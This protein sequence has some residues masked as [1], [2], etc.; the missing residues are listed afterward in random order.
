MKEDPWLRRTGLTLKDWGFTWTVEREPDEKHFGNWVVVGFRDNLALRIIRDR[1]RVSL[2]LRPASTFTQGAIYD[3][4]GNLVSGCPYE[5]ANW[6]TWDIVCTALGIPYKPEIEPLV[7][8]HEYFER[9]NHAFAPANWHR[10][11]D[12]LAHAEAEKR[13]RFTEG[14]RVP[15]HA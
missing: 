1:D 6:Y 10:T 4:D 5:S 9:V 12:W 3:S 13:R 11:R 2:D 8:F 7:S 14:H 15:A